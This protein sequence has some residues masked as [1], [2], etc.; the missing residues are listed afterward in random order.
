M[1]E[2]SDYFSKGEK[3]LYDE[4]K[5]VKQDAFPDSFKLTI[6]YTK[7]HYDNTSSVGH[8]I[9]KLQ[10]LL[11]LLDFP[12]FFVHIQTTKK[13]INQDLE[14]IKQLH[15]PS[16]NII[17]YE[18]VSGVF[19]KID[20]IRN[21]LDTLCIFPWIHVYITP[22]GKVGPC[23]DY[24]ESFPIGDLNHNS[25]SEIVNGSPIKLMR[26]Q[27][28]DGQRP[29]A[30][31]ACWIKEDAGITSL[32]NRIN[33]IYQHHM[34][35]IENTSSDGT[36]ED[37]KLRHL[38]FR[39]SN[40]CNLMCR[41]CGGKFSSRIAEEESKL[42][43]QTKYIELKLTKELIDSTLE[44]IEDNIDDLEF[45]YFAGGEP[46]LIPEHYKILDLLIKYGRTDVPVAYSTNL[47]NLKYKGIDVVDYW[48]KFSKIFLGASIDAMGTHAEYIRSGTDYNKIEEN[49]EKIKDLAMFKITS[50]IHMLNAFNLPLL[51]RHWIE[52]KKIQPSLIVFETLVSPDHMSLQVFP[53]SYKELAT[54]T[55]TDHIEWLKSIPAAENLVLSWQ[56]VLQY[57]N[58]ED[59]S[60]LLAEFFRL[61]D[62]K[63]HARKEKFED[64]IPELRDLRNYV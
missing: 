11:V 54:K 26:R 23:C 62:A 22:Q 16:D 32:R 30:C 20:T 14:T 58:A 18:I 64:A 44:Y 36:V 60:Y 55:F 42:Y 1:L 15:C 48:S 24:N 41:M 28:L 27:M 47:T 38:D 19:E 31:A 34:G 9:N 29:S 46:L 45:V 12:N 49:Y 43:D 59:K 35:L 8:A 33:Q 63:D 37:F 6:S 61:N 40:V 2:L 3:W 4:L 52:N 39:A 50:V 57:M 56:N 25:L 13:D 7:D 17:N 21:N 51:Q 53:K 5:S 10:E